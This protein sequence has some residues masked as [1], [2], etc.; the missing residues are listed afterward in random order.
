MLAHSLG[1]GS[2]LRVFC[3]VTFLTQLV[4]NGTDQSFPLLRR[5]DKSQGFWSPQFD[6]KIKMNDLTP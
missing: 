1:L 3:N 4:R 2:E 6:Q 5:G